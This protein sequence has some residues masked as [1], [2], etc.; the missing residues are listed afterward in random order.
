MLQDVHFAGR[1]IRNFSSV[2]W[3]QAYLKRIPPVKVILTVTLTAQRE[4]IMVESTE[5]GGRWI[6]DSTAYCLF[7]KQVF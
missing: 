2:R 3:Q 6:S 7:P 4:G 5:H 1:W